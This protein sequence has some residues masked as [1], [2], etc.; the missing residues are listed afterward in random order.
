MWESSALRRSARPETSGA[1][2]GVSLRDKYSSGGDA[3]QSTR[4]SSRIFRGARA[5]IG[6]LLLCAEFPS[7]LKDP[8]RGNESFCIPASI[9]LYILRS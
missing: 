7:W 6:V 1:A 8:I 4:G 3:S 2:A 5:K 9:T